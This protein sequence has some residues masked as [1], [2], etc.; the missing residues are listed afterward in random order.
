MKKAQENN[1]GK[2][3]SFLFL[4][5]LLG[6][7]FIGIFLDKNMKPEE[8]I[9]YQ[10]KEQPILLIEFINWGEY[11]NDT[12]T[13][14]FSYFIYNFGDIEVK[15]VKINCR[16]MDSD[17]NI[18]KEEIFNIGNIASNS[19]ELQESIMEY[20]FYSDDKFGACYFE[21]ADGEY[22]N[23]ADRLSVNN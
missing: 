16:I 5:M 19:Y 20:K 10:E 22:I 3:L 1:L 4:G 18:I 23:L 14:W 8:I 7:I 13:R 15:N 21:S 12:S 17:E 2:Y 11:I 9:I 6:S